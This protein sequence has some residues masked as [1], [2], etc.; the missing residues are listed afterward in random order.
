MAARHGPRLGD[1]RLSPAA[2]LELAPDEAL[3]LAIFLDRS[4]LEVLANGRQCLTQRI[5][6]RRADSRGVRLF[7][8]DAPAPVESLDAWDL[9]PVT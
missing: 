3:E 5:Y 7:A 8:H 4:V 6:P 9:L 2:P 1:R